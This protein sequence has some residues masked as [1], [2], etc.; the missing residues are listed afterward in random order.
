MRLNSKTRV[1]P[2]SQALSQRGLPRPLQIISKM[3]RLHRRV[4]HYLLDA[5]LV[6]RELSQMSFRSYLRL[7][8]LG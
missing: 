1:S 5:R 2:I 3:P 8:H 6:H 4:A 7:R